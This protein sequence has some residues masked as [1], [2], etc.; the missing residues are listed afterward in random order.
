MFLETQE[1]IQT[2][3]DIIK[4]IYVGERETQAAIKGDVI[5]GEYY[6]D[7]DTISPVINP[8]SSTG[9][10]RLGPWVEQTASFSFQRY[11]L[12]GAAP[13]KDELNRTHGRSAWRFVDGTCAPSEET[14]PDPCLPIPLRD[15]VLW[16]ASF[17]GIPGEV[18][19]RDL[20]RGEVAG[21]A[22]LDGAIGERSCTL[23]GY[24]GRFSPYTTSSLRVNSRSPQIQALTIG[25]R[26]AGHRTWTHWPERVDSFDE[27]LSRRSSLSK[28]ESE[29]WGPF[30]S[31]RGGF[32]TNSRVGGVLPFASEIDGVPGALEASTPVWSRRAGHSNTLRAQ[33]AYIGTLSGVGVE[34][35]D[36]WRSG[37]SVLPVSLGDN[38]WKQ[39]ELKGGTVA[40][41]D[42]KAEEKSGDTTKLDDE[43]NVDND[44][45]WA[46][47]KS[48]GGTQF[49]VN[50]SVQENVFD[51]RLTGAFVHSNP[52]RE[53]PAFY[54]GLRVHFCVL[55]G[56][57]SQADHPDY[58]YNDAARIPTTGTLRGVRFV[59]NVSGDVA[60]F[61]D[62]QMTTFDTPCVLETTTPPFFG[63]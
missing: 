58:L 50:E 53:V 13:S 59:H 6:R 15:P 2:S 63:I 28:R 36:T 51:A 55:G 23:G 1:K 38:L 48:L 43:R 40:W 4:R 10:S 52:W 26:W 39:D 17:P 11:A 32:S 24:S 56:F 14:P 49:G 62:L 25:D 12:G 60:G 47:H 30:T 5:A 41:F 35:N 46:I 21:G 8:Q 33:P 44:F 34:A 16:R 20:Q 61:A 57:A 27:E 9:R 42:N 37:T 7:R 19:P 29:E 45:L 22:I 31:G 54:E 3:R 18:R